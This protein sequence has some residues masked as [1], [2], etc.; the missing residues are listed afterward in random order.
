MTHTNDY[1]DSKKLLIDSKI[2][3]DCINNVLRYTNFKNYRKI[4]QQVLKQFML[5]IK[6]TVV[7]YHYE[8]NTQ[9]IYK[10]NLTTIDCIKYVNIHEFLKRYVPDE[11]TRSLSGIELVFYWLEDELMNISNIFRVGTLTQTQYF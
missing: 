4:Y 10:E 2:Q 9:T 6:N 11:D 5:R 1:D 7:F 3:Y 8:E